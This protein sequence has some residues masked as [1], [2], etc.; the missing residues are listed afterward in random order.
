MRVPRIV[1]SGGFAQQ[2]AHA[3][4]EC[5]ASGDFDYAF[6]PPRGNVVSRPIDD[7][8]FIDGEVGVDLH[9]C[10]SSKIYGLQTASVIP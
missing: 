8:L 10:S 5:D 9:V 7:E 2:I 3:N 1:P 6:Y 4:A